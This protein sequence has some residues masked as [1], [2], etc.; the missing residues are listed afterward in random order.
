MQGTSGRSSQK[1]GDVVI[2]GGGGTAEARFGLDFSLPGPLRLPAMVEIPDPQWG[3]IPT[4]IT[5]PEN[6]SKRN[7]EALMVPNSF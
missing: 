4:Q 5:L 6:S 3:N 2:W 1:A 7:A